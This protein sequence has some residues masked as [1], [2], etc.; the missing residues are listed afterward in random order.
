[1]NKLLLLFS[2]VLI[3]VGLQAQFNAEPGV[4]VDLRTLAPFENLRVSRGINVTLIEGEAPMAEIHIRNTLPEDVLIEQSGK[5]LTIRMKARIYKDVAVNVYLY[6]Q[7]LREI[8]VGT[9][10]AVYAEALLEADFLKLETGADAA[11]QLEDIDVARIEANVSASRIELAGEVAE[12][13]LNASTG[14]RFVGHALL[15]ESVKVR[16]TT[17]ANVQLQVSEK[18][19]ARS[20]TGARIEYS[21]DPREVAVSTSLGGSIDAAP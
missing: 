7:Q 21:G 2:F 19:E 6:Y 9:G 10:A 13:D 12:L 11:I 15:A 20:A 16:A 3:S 4:E 14:G 17:G 5:D 18:L 1:M 8:S